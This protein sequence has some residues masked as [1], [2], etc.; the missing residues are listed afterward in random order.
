MNK[1]VRDAL[2]AINEKLKTQRVDNNNL[3]KGHRID[4]RKDLKELGISRETGSFYVT[5]LANIRD[6][7]IWMAITENKEF[8][9]VR[10][11]I[12]SRDY[13]VNEVANQFKGGGHAL[14]SG[15]TLDSFDQLPDLVKA[16]KALL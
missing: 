8:N 13:A 2:N 3:I 6:F 9:N 15:A 10:V 1:E 7:K 5:E 16:L 12:R 14:A 11:S 4:Q